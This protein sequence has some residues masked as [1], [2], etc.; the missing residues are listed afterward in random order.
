MNKE[1]LKKYIENKC[2]SE[3]I[4]EVF[5]WISKDS[6]STSSNDIVKK[7]WDYLKD[8]TDIES[9]NLR[10]Q[11]LDKIHHQLNLN[12]FSK[13]N[14]RHINRVSRR[15]KI[16][17]IVFYAASLLIIPVLTI[18]IYKQVQITDNIQTRITEDKPVMNEI[19]SPVGSRINIEL[20]D[21]TKV[22]LNHGSSMTYPQRFWGN[23]RTVILKGEAFFEVAHNPNQPFIVET[24]DFKVVA[25][26]TSFNVK[27][28]ENANVAFEAALESGEIGIKYHDQALETLKPNQ[29]FS[30]NG[31]SNKAE[32]KNTDLE[33]YISWKDGR[34][35]FIDDSFENIAE[36]LSRWYNVEIELMNPKIKE[37]TYTATFVDES[38]YQIL[39]MLEI[40]TPIRYKISERHKLEDGTF[41]KRKISVYLKNG[42]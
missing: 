39:E 21:G 28:Y 12:Y 27:S 25:T 15:N 19:I 11:R 36:R 5:R 13:T 17:N 7:I 35:V 24:N 40:V 38:L 14:N 30:Y 1:L 22:W 10:Q 9:E 2:S 6:Y 33:K 3:E 18:L 32:I 29:L 20:A 23:N 34:L 4:D 42:D 41:S 31:V 37:L 8:E 16:T 26:G